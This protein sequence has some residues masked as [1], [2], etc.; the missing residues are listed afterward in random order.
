MTETI[1]RNVKETKYIQ[2]CFDST[3]KSP[4]HLYV[5]HQLSSNTSYDLML[6]NEEKKNELYKKNISRRGK[7]KRK[8][9]KRRKKRRNTMEINNCR[10]GYRE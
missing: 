1:R 9:I 5:P 4:C 7:G 6:K 10:A 8:E 3:R 2:I